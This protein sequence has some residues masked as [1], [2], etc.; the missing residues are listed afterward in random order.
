MINKNLEEKLT[1]FMYCNKCKT[2]LKT[3]VSYKLD[4]T[5]EFNCLKCNR[6]WK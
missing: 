2:H 5:I 3:Y 6:I 4:N 1:K